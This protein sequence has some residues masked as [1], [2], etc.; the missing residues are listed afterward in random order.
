MYIYVDG[1]NYI[2]ILLVYECCHE[3]NIVNVLFLFVS[4]CV[5]NDILFMYPTIFFLVV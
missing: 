2:I 3:T 5:Y 4:R 1:T